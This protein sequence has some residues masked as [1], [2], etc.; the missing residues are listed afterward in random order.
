MPDDETTIQE[1]AAETAAAVPAHDIPPTR[2]R[3]QPRM[4]S[5]PTI[6]SQ[7]TRRNGTSRSRSCPADRAGGCWGW[8]LI[9]FPW[10]C[11]ACC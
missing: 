8:A 2:P 3:P 10:R 4:H 6:R 1:T 9:P 7:K 5:L 11:S